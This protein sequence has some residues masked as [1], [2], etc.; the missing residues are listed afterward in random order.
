MRTVVKLKKITPTFEIIKNPLSSASIPEFVLLTDDGLAQ[1]LLELEGLL[2][3]SEVFDPEEQ[4]HFSQVVANLE[5]TLPLMRTKNLPAEAAESILFL[6]ERAIAVFEEHGI[7]SRE[8]H[9][10][11]K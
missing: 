2:K 5:L 11:W 9:Q 10:P 1:V 7:M 6:I 8:P 4:D 3:D